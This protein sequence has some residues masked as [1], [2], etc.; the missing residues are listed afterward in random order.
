VI[1]PLLNRLVPQIAALH[2][3][4]HLPE[5]KPILFQYMMIS[6]TSTLSEFGP[7]MRVT[8]NLK[9][10]DPRVVESYWRTVEAFIF[11]RASSAPAAD[12]ARRRSAGK[13]GGS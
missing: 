4:G 8:G 13:G 9:A 7:E 3:T 1:M 10:D 2:A 12:V 11:D 6:L 5:I